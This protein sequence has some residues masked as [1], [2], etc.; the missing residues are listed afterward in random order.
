VWVTETGFWTADGMYWGGAGDGEAL[1]ATY[2]PRALL[3]FWLAGAKRTYIYELADF[4]SSVFFGLIRDDGTPKPAFYAI[5]N[6]LTLLKDPGPPIT[7]DSLSYSISGAGP[8]LHQLLLEKRDGSHYLAL[9]IEA[10]G[11]DASTLTPMTVPLQDVQVLLGRFPAA[12]TAY[13]WDGVGTMT[14]IPINPAQT[15]AVS[16]GPNITI[17]KIQ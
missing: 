10:P 11:M 17:L 15:V 14:T 3:E 12:V 4:S 6:L 9:W 13:Q 1:S 8:Q 7:P 5:S 2:A 16:I